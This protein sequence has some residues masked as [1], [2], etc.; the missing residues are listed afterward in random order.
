MLAFQFLEGSYSGGVIWDN[1]EF[2]GAAE[3]MT[4]PNSIQ[5][6]FLVQGGG[7]I[8]YLMKRP[9]SVGYLTSRLRPIIGR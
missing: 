6:G 2:I 9:A 5:Y 1:A 8:N 7:A 3:L 4:G